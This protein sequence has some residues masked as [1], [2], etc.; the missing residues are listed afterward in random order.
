MTVW[1]VLGIDATSDVR[2][3]KRAYAVKLKVTRPD[4]DPAAFQRLHDAFQ[5][6][7]SQAPHR[8]SD[9]A[10]APVLEVVAE[11]AAP[12]M[13]ARH[14]PPRLVVQPPLPKGPS[15]TDQAMVLW[16]GFIGTS[17]V[18]P[19]LHLN[20]LA[21]SDAL[22]SLAVREEFELCAARHCAKAGCSDELREAIFKHFSWEV[23]HTLIARQLP[24]ETHRLLAHVRAERSH[25]FFLQQQGSDPAVKTLLGS[26]GG[27]D[28]LKTCDASFMRKMRVLVQAIPAYHPD[29]LRLKLDQE[30]FAKWE[31]HVA[32]KRYYVQTALHSL[33]ATMILS[34][35]II[36]ALSGID[37][38]G[39]W[40]G[41]AMLAS[42]IVAFGGFAWF[43]FRQSRGQAL[44]DTA[45]GARLHHL[46]YAV[47]Y[48]PRWQFAWLLPFALA[49][50]AVFLPHPSP[51]IRYL[52]FAALVACVLV[53]SFSYSAVV[54]GWNFLI[55]IVVSIGIG[56]SLSV[57]GL[58][59]DPVTC[60][61]MVYCAVLVLMRGG[62]DLLAMASVP[63]RAVLPLRVTWLAG[64]ALLI[65]GAGL[66]PALDHAA[67]YAAVSWLWLLAGMLLTYPSI[68]YF[69]AL[70][71]TVAFHG[72]V[73][74]A[75]TKP[76]LLTAQPMSQVLAGLL[77][78]TVFMAVNMVRARSNQHPF[79]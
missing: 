2:A 45:I 71:G 6:A 70:I 66:A 16:A 14:E 77:Y 35:L 68:H 78:V 38:A 63:M 54:R 46:L 79:S 42:A 17:T 73:T 69:F 22:V 31:R 1:Q 43:A 64:V 26:D 52:V 10:P 47:R 53:V 61:M 12:A 62:S 49:S 76:T 27:I 5:Y 9:D 20:R 40:S 29:M 36:F 21:D 8:S 34:L 39:H 72:I 7:L 28:L 48:R 33:I 67:L 19:R 74:N 18:Q 57:K 11:A 59:F 55:S 58:A 41:T 65:C 25:A 60:A 23:D 32:R 3:I 13:V 37:S 24:G 51:M 56:T 30:R 4:D 75:V 50:T 44:R 15:A